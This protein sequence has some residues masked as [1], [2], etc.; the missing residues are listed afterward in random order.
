MSEMPWPNS[1]TDDLF[2]CHATSKHVPFI[3]TKKNNTA[4]HHAQLVDLAELSA[5]HPQLLQRYLVHAHPANTTANTGG[6]STGCFLLHTCRG[7]F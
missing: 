3:T 2:M 1:L 4:E 5:S 7:A 6:N